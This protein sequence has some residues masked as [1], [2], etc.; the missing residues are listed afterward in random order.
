MLETPTR[1]AVPE[2][3]MQGIQRLIRDG[4]Y[5]A[6]DYVRNNAPAVLGAAGGQYVLK[7]STLACH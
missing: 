6:G 3:A 1:G 4:G 7:G 5:Q 2:L